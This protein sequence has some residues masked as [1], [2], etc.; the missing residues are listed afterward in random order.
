MTPAKLIL[1]CIAEQ[2]GNQWQALCLDLCLAAQADT[3]EQAK[4]KLEAMIL[5]Y[6]HDALAGEDHAYAAQLLTRKAPLGQWARYYW[7]CF[8]SRSFHIRSNLR[9]LFTETLPLAP[10]QHGH[11]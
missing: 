7:Y 3:F 5:E 4:A 2:V 6:V 9:R 10:V 1:H 11:A 8:L